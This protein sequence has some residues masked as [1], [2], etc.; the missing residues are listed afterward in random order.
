MRIRII[1]ILIFLSF[2]C[3]AN[4]VKDYAFKTIRTTQGLTDDGV[5]SVLIDSR[6]YVWIG[7]QMG[8]NRYDGVR[9]KNFY[10]NDLGLSS[11]FISTICE[12]H[13]GN[14]WVGT[15]EGL[16]VYDYRNATFWKPACQDGLSRLFI[17]S[18]A[19]N[20]EG[21]IMVLANNG[22]LFT[23]E[24]SKN[25]LTS[26]GVAFPPGN[27][28]MVF[29]AE[30]NLVII[31]SPKNL[32]KYS[33]GEAL[34]V[35]PVNH[36]DIFEDE[37]IWGPVCR[38]DAEGI[39]YV[40]TKKNGVFEVD[41][42]RNVAKPLLKW[43]LDEKPTGLTLVENRLLWCTTTAG[44]IRYDIK[45]G[46]VL[47]MRHDQNN[48]FSISEDYLSCIAA[49]AKGDIWVGTSKSG[50]SF[51]NESM[52]R[53]KKFFQTDNGESLSN[54]VIKGFCEDND[55]TVWITT[56]RMGLLK[57]IPQT[58]S[59]ERVKNLRI[60][61]FLS[62]ITSDSDALWIG[63]QFGLLKYQPS[64]GEIKKYLSENTA[65]ENRVTAVAITSDKSLFV[66][67]V[68]G[69]RKYDPATD[70]FVPVPGLEN[71]TAESFV[72]DKKGNLWIATYST[73][74]FKMSEDGEVTSFKNKTQLMTSEV[75]ID[76]IGNVWVIGKDSA[77][78]R[79]DEQQDSF[80]VIS[81]SE[82]NLLSK[83]I[84]LCAEQGNSGHIWLS[85]TSGLLDFDSSS[86]AVS[87]IY[88]IR[89]GILE[90]NFCKASL[91][92]RNGDC[93]FGSVN[94]FISFHSG[95]S[96]PR[97]YLVDI[98]AL[99]VGNEEIFGAN[100]YDYFSIGPNQHCFSVRLSTPGVIGPAIVTCQLIGRDKSPILIPSDVQLNY[101]DLPTGSYTLKI[102]GHPDI[103]VSVEPPFFLSPIGV[104][105]ILLAFIA[106]ISLIIFINNKK[107]VE[108]NQRME[109]DLKRKQEE[110]FLKEKMNFLSNV[111][112]EIKT[113]LTLMKTPLQS[114]SVSNSLTENERKEVEII[115]NSADYLDKLS[116]ELLEFI[117]VEEVGYVLSLKPTDLIETLSFL[118]YNFSDA[119]KNRN[120]RI[121]FSHDEDQLIVNADERAL[122]K[123]LNNLLHNA[124]KYSESVFTVMVEHEKGIAYV[125]VRND[126]PIIPTEEREN[127]F[128]PFVCL[129]KGSS[130]Y[131]PS[132]GIGLTLARK[133]ATLQGGNLTLSSSQ[134][135]EFVFSI[136]VA[137]DH[138]PQVVEY[139]PNKVPDNGKPVILI[140]EDND[141]L[142]D[143]LKEKMS[144]DFNVVTVKSAE[145]GLN[146]LKVAQVN[147]VVTDIGMPGMGGV[148][149]C[150]RVRGN[151][152]TSKLPI[153]VISAI[154]SERVK[155]DCVLGGANIYIEKPF[156][157]DYLTASVNSLLNMDQSGKSAMD[158][159]PPKI[160]VD[161]R[162]TR[163]LSNLNS[164]IER[165]IGDES[166][167][168][169]QLE[170]ELFMSHSSLNRKM[171]SL[172]NTTS[173]DYIRATR[174][175]AAAVI[176]K[177]QKVNITE[178]CYMVGFSTP[179]YFSKCFKDYFGVTPA[180]YVN[181][182]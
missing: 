73:G 101:Y 150:R 17:S 36:P 80:Q 58:G 79:Y 122:R 61:Q 93:L 83:G 128:K 115:S 136:P 90:N 112:H 35:R 102:S 89:S 120:L 105:I 104:I 25:L 135:T 143:Y 94:G 155:T 30:D 177:E 113:P 34:P 19:C 139:T 91:K 65:S 70:S 14:V 126:G 22:Q 7:T 46:Q 137:E 149:L 3:L 43:E 64:S 29:D 131:S 5:K 74:V 165:H 154:A 60:P 59:V 52:N 4:D 53:F 97:D 103:K 145:N 12:D 173:V 157:I 72:E 96:T 75:F 127:I 92:T 141:Y 48:P 85:T 66:G 147:L 179:A 151:T 77:I 33:N 172:L 117:R 16:A 174:L 146:I 44:L 23:Y 148:E 138:R 11:N 6:G 99:F 158:T 28:R 142:A 159:P 140:V 100:N 51:A 111:V 181:A 8:L 133:L 47:R 164:V 163:F 54:C 32:Y 130:I 86:L 62:S 121:D 109:E 169:K 81:A 39:I 182:V 45:T 144:A 84:I 118:C 134:E 167:S 13:D 176:L 24:S 55:G 20:S 49:N 162:D 71:I 178:V 56:E 108:R 124:L 166:F 114:L 87:A 106:M 156:T 31:V 160:V 1:L 123:I 152:E 67:V 41:L 88:D 119:A 125:K 168:V 129:G 27:G 69:V 132:F 153:I 95:L 161:D 63:T 76:R 50:V 68:S 26:T 57:Y 10:G 110:E 175:K 40:S 180:E 15:S 78:A 42:K 171:A 98:D 9:I 170:A 38:S 82:T 2:T 37:E 116:K 21:L 107:Q 18:I